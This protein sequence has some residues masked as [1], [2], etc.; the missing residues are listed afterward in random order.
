MVLFGR[1]LSGFGAL[2]AFV[3]FAPHLKAQGLTDMLSSSPSRAAPS[4]SIL[5][6]KLSSDV[7]GNVYLKNS[8]AFIFS[9]TKDQEKVYSKDSIFVGPNQGATIKISDEFGGGE[10]FLEANTVITI[11]TAK[12]KDEK[13][14]VL[15]LKKGEIS[16]KKVE[17]KAST[18]S[19]KRKAPKTQFIIQKGKSAIVVNNTLENKAIRGNKGDGF[20]ILEQSK[21]ASGKTVM[22]PVK[23]EIPVFESSSL[24]ANIEK[25]QD[26]STTLKFVP[27]AKVEAIEK[28]EP[29]P[30]LPEPVK[31][32]QAKIQE[33]KK[34]IQPKAPQKKVAELK[35][36]K[37]QV[38]KRVA[39]SRRPQRPPLRFSFLLGG[40]LIKQNLNAGS[41][42][43][44]ANNI[45]FRARLSYDLT[46]NWQF[47]LRHL[48]TLKPTSEELKTKL[49]WS[50]FSADYRIISRYRGASA[51]RPNLRL[52]A[53]IERYT[54]A[55]DT[56]AQNTEFLQSYTSF[57]A[58][59]RSRFTLAPRWE[60]GGDLLGTVLSNGYKLHVQGDLMYAIT[61]RYSVGG[62]YWTEIARV[63]DSSLSET[64]LAIEAYLQVKF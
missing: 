43:V 10:I 1:H 46:P 53:G 38:K 50:A 14:P 61:R 18:N 17:K 27:T 63:P 29:T 59:F 56:S 26:L 39:R 42:A 11:A 12:T 4:N 44:A 13:L 25:S 5:F 24:F 8:Q 51:W 32:V 33:I 62:G 31:P 20:E 7:E 9:E 49:S 2:C 60:I 40:A 3:L 15:E 57:L 47:T 36:K 16:I 22:T 64:T 34:P 55:V 21:N 30:E 52:V 23:V 37:V 58:G 45:G 28:P 19:K 35:P 41:S 48:A 54:N 6:G